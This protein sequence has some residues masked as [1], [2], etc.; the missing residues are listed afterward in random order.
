MGFHHAVAKCA[1]RLF[2]YLTRGLAVL[3]AAK[4]SSTEDVGG[5]FGNL[6]AQTWSA[7]EISEY[8]SLLFMLKLQCLDPRDIKQI[9]VV[10][11]S[12]QPFNHKALFQTSSALFRG[13]TTTASVT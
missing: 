4:A 3:D 7:T 2:V 13:Y 5:M 8:Q 6:D 11:R 1:A 10:R 9:N 12:S